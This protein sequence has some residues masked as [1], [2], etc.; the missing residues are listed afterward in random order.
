M[1]F[2]VMHLGAVPT[3]DE[4]VLIAVP[5][6][7]AKTVIA[8]PLEALPHFLPLLDRAVQDGPRAR[9]PACASVLPAEVLDD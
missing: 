7:D 6:A 2:A 5:R 9:C 8:V 4:E 3:P 1:H